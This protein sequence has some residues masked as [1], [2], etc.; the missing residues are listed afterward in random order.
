MSNPKNKTAIVTGASRRTI[1]NIVYVAVILGTSFVLQFT[2]NAKKPQ[3]YF[4]SVPC[5]SSQ[6]MTDN[7]NSPTNRNIV[8]RKEWINENELLVNGSV[9]ENCAA[10]IKDGDYELQGDTL[11]LT[12]YAIGNKA[13]CVCRHNVT[14]RI[15]NLPKKEYEIYI[16][17]A[18]RE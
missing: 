8:G 3:L 7:T 12:Y 6:Y 18:H 14:Y 11:I 17:C 9:E 16:Q 5:S 1:K 2:V 4:S 13:N 10:E 15:K